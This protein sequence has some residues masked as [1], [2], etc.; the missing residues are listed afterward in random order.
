LCTKLQTFQN[1]Y[2]KLKKPGSMLFII[3][4]VMLI[5]GIGMRIL[6]NGRERGYHEDEVWFGHSL[7][8]T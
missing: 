3:S 8:A 7:Q 1:K 4:L 5:C 6:L 2:L